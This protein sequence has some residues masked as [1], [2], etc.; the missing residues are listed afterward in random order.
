[1]GRAS[2]VISG[3]A[4][5]CDPPPVHIG[6]T[7]DVL[8]EMRV[9]R[10]CIELHFNTPVYGKLAPLRGHSNFNHFDSERPTSLRQLEDPSVRASS[11]RSLLRDGY[12]RMFCEFA[13]QPVDE[14]P[15]SQR[16]LPAVRIEERHGTRRWPV[17]RQ[18]FE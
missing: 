15:H 1:M 5:P 3:L 12:F 16:E 6:G 10:I 9:G 8:R 13:C 7:H 17:G 14:H 11:R 18:N 2:V 4:H